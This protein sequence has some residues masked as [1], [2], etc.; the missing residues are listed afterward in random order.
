MNSPLENDLSGE[1]LHLAEGY[2]V[3]NSSLLAYVR[4]NVGLRAL[5][6][7]TFFCVKTN[8]LHPGIVILVR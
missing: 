8:S 7:I 4:Q 5:P 6:D 1:P 3:V 2:F